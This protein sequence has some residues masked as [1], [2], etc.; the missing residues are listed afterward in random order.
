MSFHGFPNENFGG[1][2]RVTAYGFP[3]CSFWMNAEVGL[4]AVSNLDPIST[5][6]DQAGQI[7]FVQNN[8]L[9]QPRLAKNVA[10]FGG[11]DLVD[12]H[13]AGRGLQAQVNITAG[14]G[15]KTLAVVYEYTS[16]ATQSRIIG[17]NDFSNAR[18]TGFSFHHGHVQ[19]TT[20]RPWVGY[21]VGANVLYGFDGAPVYANNPRI[22]IFTR[23]VMILN[24]TQVTINL[25]GSP[26]TSGPI[27]WI[28][29]NG[30]FGASWSGVFRVGDILL[31]DREFSL[32]EC[33]DL[34]NTLNLKYALY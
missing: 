3:L 19:N 12:F 30:A 7:P 33:I 15:G 6:I 27:S 21:G 9:Y 5:W 32:S 2:G 16:V 31:Y 24:G 25:T 17:D 23:N 26:F 20:F 8:S 22:L 11:R 18:S 14:T 13:T 28:G 1:G 4:N 10:S 29:S 34:S